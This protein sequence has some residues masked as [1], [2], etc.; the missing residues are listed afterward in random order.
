MVIS[1]AL[2]QSIN[3]VAVQVL[4]R[5]GVNASVKFMEENL[6]ISTL[7]DLDKSLAISLGGLSKGISPLELTAAYVPFVNRGIYTKPYS[8]AKVTDSEGRI[9][10]E[11]KKQS[12]KAMSEQTAS[13]MAN[14]LKGVV[15]YGTGGSARFSGAYGIGG[16]TGTTDKDIDRWFV[17]FTPYYVGGIWIGYDNPQSMSY[18]GSNPGVG[19]WKRVMQ[20]IHSAKKLP[21]MP[22]RQ[23]AE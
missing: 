16:K 23:A 5:L 1:Y 20:Q 19:M 9:I 18:M 21:G 12:H 8:Y 2:E 4:E 3:T 17:G 10:L 13:I 22:F 14:M 15:D 6:K 11:N 7:T